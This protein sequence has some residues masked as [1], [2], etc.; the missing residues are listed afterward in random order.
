M[1]GT[2]ESPDGRQLVVADVPGLI[3]GAS[4]GR[5]A[6]ARVPRAPRA[7]AHARSRHRRVAS[8]RRAVAPHRRRARRVRRRPR[9]A[10]ADRR[11]EQDRSRAGSG[12]HVDDPRVIAVL[13][14]SCATGEGH[15]RA[16]VGV[17]SPSFPSRL[18]RSAAGRA[19][20]LPGLQARAE[21]R[22]RGGCCERTAASACSGRRRRRRSSSA[23]C[24]AAGARKGATVEIGDEELELA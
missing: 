16:S 8:R 1:L 7:C 4:R 2:V 20:G 14:M 6:R 3:E 19:R 18:S 15:R 5:R 13:R 9:R 10:P 21:G 12:V 17:S 23:R 22:G 24:K 11:A